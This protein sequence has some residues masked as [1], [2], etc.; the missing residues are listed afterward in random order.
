ML[1][2][3]FYPAHIDPT[4]LPKGVWYEPKGD[5]WRCRQ[6]DQDIGKAVKVRLCSGQA[7][8]SQIWQAYETRQEH[9]VTT[10]KSLSLEFQK[11]QKWRELSPLTQSDYRHCH[12]KICA[13]PTKT[14][15]FGDQP[16]SKWTTA[17]V[18]KY[19]D[20]TKQGCFVTTQR[21]AFAFLSIEREGNLNRHES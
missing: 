13:T 6:T 2:S 21:N 11:S 15:D 1:K 10:F 16:I 8:L 4:K 3:K 14:G 17:T 12:A 18:L 20:G 5:R 19:R 7:T 9:Y